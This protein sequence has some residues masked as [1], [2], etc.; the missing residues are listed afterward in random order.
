MSAFQFTLCFY[1]ISLTFASPPKLLQLPSHFDLVENISFPLT[2][3]LL[4]GDGQITFSWS[5]NGV[6]LENSSDYRIDSS[7]LK[8]SFLTLP[9]V[10]RKH[11]GQY[12]CRA[13]NIFG[14]D[15]LTRTKINVQGKKIVQCVCL[16]FAQNVALRRSFRLNN[17]LISCLIYLPMYC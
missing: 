10:Q 12:E 5:H 7:S 13:A 3:S 16:S 4:S 8:L 2:C 11:A 15:D 1:L 17:N 14:E 9:N 6:Q